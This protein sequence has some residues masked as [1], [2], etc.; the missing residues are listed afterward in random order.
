L[1]W[2]AL[3]YAPSVSLQHPLFR[4]TCTVALELH[5]CAQPALLRSTCLVWRW[6][7]NHPKGSWRFSGTAAKTTRLRCG[8]APTF[9]RVGECLIHVRSCANSGPV[10][11]YGCT[12]A[13]MRL[14]PTRSCADASVCRSNAEWGDS[15]DGCCRAADAA[16]GGDCCCRRGIGQRF[17]PV[18]LSG[19]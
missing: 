11:N 10:P 2:P 17:A 18:P 15:T 8:A 12:C 16:A 9:S 19:T 4:S 6:F 3:L 13:M 14:S 1:W 7:K 5:C